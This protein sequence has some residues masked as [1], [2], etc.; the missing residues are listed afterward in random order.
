MLIITY[1]VYIWRRMAEKYKEK[2]FKAINPYFY[3][4]FNN[5]KNGYCRSEL[6]PKKYTGA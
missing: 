2:Y 6:H 4:A 1:A 5:Y 3:Y